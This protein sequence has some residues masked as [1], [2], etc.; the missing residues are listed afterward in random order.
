MYARVRHEPQKC[1]VCPKQFTPVRSD[2]LYCCT[3]CKRRAANYKHVFQAG[4]R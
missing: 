2:Q 1:A 3:A 4:R